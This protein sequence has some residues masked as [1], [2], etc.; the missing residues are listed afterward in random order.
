MAYA[1]E[2]FQIGFMK[3]KKKNNIPSHVNS[4]ELLKKY[5]IEEGEKFGL[6]PPIF[7]K[8]A[9]RQESSRNI[10]E[11]LYLMYRLKELTMAPFLMPFK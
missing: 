3:Y 6:T 8:A 9:A 2:D 5:L 7:Q 11:S 4:T 10:L 1:L